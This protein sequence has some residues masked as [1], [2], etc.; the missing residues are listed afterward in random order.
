MTLSSP[1]TV[2]AHAA[3]QPPSKM[4]LKA[5]TQLSLDAA[6]K[7][8]LVKSANDIAVVVAETV[9]GSQAGSA[10]VMN[11]TAR[12]LG[13]RD[14]HFVN[15]HGLPDTNHYSSVHDMAMLRDF[16]RYRK[17]YGYAGVHFGKHLMRSANREYLR[18]VRGANGSKTGY[19]CNAGYNVAVSATRGRR[20]VVAIVFG[21]ASGLERAAKARQLIEEG[22]DSGG[23][24]Y[25]PRKAR[26][27]E[28]ATHDRRSLPADGY[29]RRNKKLG[30]ADLLQAYV[31]P[32]AVRAAT[33]LPGVTTAYAG[34]SARILPDQIQRSKGDTNGS[35]HERQE[36]RL[37]GGSG[38]PHRQAPQCRQDGEREPEDRAQC[39]ESRAAARA[40]QG[41]SGGDRRHPLRRR[42]AAAR[43]TRQGNFGPDHRQAA[44]QC[45]RRHPYPSPFA[46]LSGKVNARAPAQGRHAQ[47]N[48]AM[49]DPQTPVR[50]RRPPEPVPLT[51][52]LGSGKTTLLNRILADP[53]MKN[54]AVIVNEFGDIGLDHLLVATA[55]EGVIE[56]SS[57]C[58][59]CTIRGDLVSTLEDLLRR[60]DN[61]RIDALK[62]VVIE[63]TGLADPAPI[64]HTVMLHPYL[65]MRYR[66]DG[67]ITTID[68]ING[69]DTLDAHEEAVKQVAVAD[70]LVLTKSDLAETPEARNGLAA[71]RDRVHRLN[72][73]TPVLD[74]AKGEADVPGLLN[75]GLY[76]PD[77]KIPDVRRWLGEEAKADED[78]AHSHDHGHDHGHEHH[79]DHGH[80]HHH[81]HDVNRHDDHIRAFTLASD[82]PIPATGLEMFLDLIRSAHGPNLLRFK[83]I[84][85]IAEDLDH[86]VV[87]HGVQHVFHPPVRLDAWPDEDHRTRLVCITR[88]MP[89]GFVEGLFAAFTDTA[90]TDTPDSAAM[91]DNPLAVSGFKGNFG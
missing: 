16:P 54:T 23:L 26:R 49:T 3:A 62:R 5:G 52:F 1:V 21:A 14:T 9:G 77:T 36:G 24:F 76:D 47:R 75:C 67:V 59:C 33:N 87:L 19:I 60:L 55:D 83:G 80:D 51:G 63:T 73:T 12:K 20:T 90:Q 81:H 48:V 50:R 79:H 85:A 37:G 74:A 53:A 30:V 86:P 57:G 29:C 71:L 15:P 91:L 78:H 22:F 58:L 17:L 7:V 35:A 31:G 65:I 41:R 11:E 70:Q 4:G 69:A 34:K 66:L 61:G 45:R 8:M 40:R 42:H 64:L 10:A 84:V 25:P 18:R 46:A 88:D 13:I 39:Q 43:Q 72:P 27:H 89:K 28:K 38:P 2:S 44:G 32:S 56:L 68:A 6:L 82:K